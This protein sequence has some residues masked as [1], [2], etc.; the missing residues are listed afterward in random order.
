MGDINN[1]NQSSIWSNNAEL[2][3]SSNQNEKTGENFNTFDKKVTRKSLFDMNALAGQ[4]LVKN[5]K[6]EFKGNNI[7]EDKKSGITI[8]SEKLATVTEDMKPFL[9]ASQSAVW[10]ANTLSEFAFESA[11]KQNLTDP[12]AKAALIQFAAAKEFENTEVLKN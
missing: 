2:G 9:R 4:S 5:K 12:M 10:R 11:V 3:F 7:L 8:T 6:S 1:K